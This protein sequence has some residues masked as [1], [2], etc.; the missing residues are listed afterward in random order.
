MK[1]QKI[2]WKLYVNCFSIE[3]KI[4]NWCFF[5]ITP[6][7]HLRIGTIVNN[8][9]K[10]IIYI[11]YFESFQNIMLVFKI[12]IWSTYVMFLG[13]VQNQRNRLFIRIR[14]EFATSKTKT[15]HWINI[16]RVLGWVKICVCVCNTASLISRIWRCRVS[17]FLSSLI[18]PIFLTIKFRSCMVFN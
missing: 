12:L 2:L 6:V 16:I 10:E 1:Q 5:A 9:S 14:S 15:E 18:A 7:Q 3:Q 8:D 4:A 11:R 17:S 13:V